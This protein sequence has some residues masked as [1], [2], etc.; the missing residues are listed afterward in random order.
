MVGKM[1][2]AWVVIFPL[3][4]DEHVSGS[5]DGVSVRD[6]VGN[7]VAEES[8]A[9]SAYS[10]IMEGGTESAASK[11]VELEGPVRW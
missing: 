3:K 9:G 7:A 11:P 5:S 8:A 10:S 4:A 2:L 6:G 1:F